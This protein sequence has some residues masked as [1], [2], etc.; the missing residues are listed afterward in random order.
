MSPEQARGAT[1]RQ[2]HRHLGLRLRP[3]PDADR[4]PGVR[5]RDALGHHRRDPRPR[6]GLVGASGRDVAVAPAAAAALP[7]EG[8]A[9]PP[10]R[11]RRRAHRDP[12]MRVP[13]FRTARPR[14]PRKAPRSSSMGA[15]ALLAAI[16][17]AGLAAAAWLVWSD[18]GAAPAETSSAL[19]LART[20][21]L[22]N[23]PAREFGPA[24][25]P[26][27]KW[28]AYY[29]DAR[30]PTDIW[31]KYVDS[32]ATLNL[33]ASLAMR[34]PVRTNIS[35][36]A[37]SPDGGSL[38]FF[39]SR[40]ATQNLYDTWVMAAPL[41]GTPRKLL[42]GM[43][44]VQWSPDGTRLAYILP[45]SSLGDA[46]IVADADGS[47]P[48]EIL[49][50]A[51]GRH[52]HWP[53]WSR[54]GQSIYFIYTY[55]PWN[56]EQSEIYRVSAA[57]GVPEAVVQSTRRA[58]YPVPLPGGDLLYSGN[59]DSVDLGLWWQ[60]GRGGAASAA[61]GRHRR[62]RRRTASRA[63]AG[64]SCP[65]SSTSGSR[66]S[67]STSPVRGRPS[68]DHRRL[69]RRY[70][71]VARSDERSHRLQLD[72]YGPSQRVDRASRMAAI[73]VRSPRKPP[74]IIIRS[75][76][77][78]AARLRSC[79]I[80]AVSR[81]IWLISADGGAPR[82]LTPRRRSSTRSAGRA[83][84][85]ASYLRRRRPQGRLRSRP[86]RWPMAACRPSRRRSRRPL[87]PGRT[88]P[89]RSPTSRRRWTSSRRRRRRPRASCSDS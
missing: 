36:L 59:P 79:R 72:A 62:I 54:D 84:E 28:V 61:H 55:Q 41:G 71:P 66:L 15:P 40:D 46:L 70:R 39:G 2:A 64:G 24:I 35:G 10:A 80:A 9:A 43:Q 69:Q 78:T 29:S 89:T 4:A 12:W 57:G 73:R 48:R 60:P 50:A 17:L 3:L 45:G 13:A 85:P 75:S 68:C 27:G 18:R 37:I 6:A 14:P 26:D 25:S 34:L 20:V 31:V 30:G 53:T 7:R 44:G 33:T 19:R 81:G 8:S 63:T 52:V 16:G 74:T 49:P 1:G 82:L 23:T 5:G 67:P 56:T 51:G 86:W 32:G 87:R 88:P 42:E 47:N 58:V 21:R 77:P 83:T 76:H 22:T 38:A 65:W 11:H